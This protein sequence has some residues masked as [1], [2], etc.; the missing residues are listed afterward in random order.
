M[1]LPFLSS[2]KN[3][4]REVFLS[5]GVIEIL[6]LFSIL[7]TCG[8]ALYGSPPESSSHQKYIENFFD[9]FNVILSSGN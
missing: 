9:K 4:I 7:S 1:N 8:I 3:K 5:Y 6:S 2:K